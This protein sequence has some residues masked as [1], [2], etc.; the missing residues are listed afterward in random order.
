M[1]TLLNGLKVSKQ[2]RERVAAAN[3]AARE[4]EIVRN[5]FA[6]SGSERS[7]WRSRRPSPTRTR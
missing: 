7:W 2:A 4:I 5:R 1:I 6:T 3:L